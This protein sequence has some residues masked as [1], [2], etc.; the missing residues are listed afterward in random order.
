MVQWFVEGL[1]DISIL[2]HFVMSTPHTMQKT[3]DIAEKLGSCDALE[4]R[5]KPKPVFEE[6]ASPSISDVEV[7]RVI[8]DLR[9]ELISAEKP[10]RLTNTSSVSM[11]ISR[12]ACYRC[13]ENGHIALE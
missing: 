8:E 6:P 12:G 9:L 13:G 4:D 1:D 3:V 7:P 10:N 11:P 5:G 2:R